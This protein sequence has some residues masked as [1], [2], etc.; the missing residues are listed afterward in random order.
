M[1]D[2]K[3]HIYEEMRTWLENSVFK[4]FDNPNKITT[5]NQ[6]RTEYDMSLLILTS[7]NVLAR[8]ITYKSAFP[9]FKPSR[10]PFLHMYSPRLTPLFI[11]MLTTSFK[12]SPS[13]H[14]TNCLMSPIDI[15]YYFF[16]GF[17]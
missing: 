16:K 9:T 12:H 17:N 15:C 7:G 8:T 14:I 10:E 5:A 4:N 6:D 11:R 2:E 1:L 3:M 13:Y